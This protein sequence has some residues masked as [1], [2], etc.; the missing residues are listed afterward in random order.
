MYQDMVVDS[1]NL[2]IF[3]NFYTSVTFTD[4]THP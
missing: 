1:I 4:L 3:V 2:K